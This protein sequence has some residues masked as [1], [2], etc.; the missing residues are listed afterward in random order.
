MS[1]LATLKSRVWEVLEKNKDTRDSDMELMLR[2]RKTYYSLSLLDVWDHSLLV[3]N[4]IRFINLPQLDVISRIRRAYNQ[5]WLYIS[6]NEEVRKQRRQNTD[7][8]LQFLW[9]R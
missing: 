9:Y 5:S 6:D 7:R 8:Y 4:N 3:T 2:I 1:N